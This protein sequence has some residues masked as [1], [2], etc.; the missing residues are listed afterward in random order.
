MAAFSVLTSLL[1]VLVY[2]LC[3]RTCGNAL[4]AFMGGVCGWFF[5]TVGL[6][7][8]P[9]LIGHIFLVIELIVLEIAW[10]GRRRVL[11]FLPPLFAIWV[12]CHGSYFFGLGVLFAYTL[13]SFCGGNWG[14]ISGKSWD[15]SGRRL[16]AAILILSAAALC[17]NP[18]GVHLLIY[19]LN[20]MFQQS[21][22]TTVV[23]EWQAPD[24]RS[25]T[26]IGMI[27]ALIA[28]FMIA[29][30]R[31]A[32]I[33]IRELL[34]VGAALALASQH[35]RVLFIFGI[36]VSP[37]LCRLAGPVLGREHRK[38]LPI[39]NA[40]LIA[41]FVAIIAANFPRRE[42]LERQVRE[43][44]PVAAV[45]FIRR[46]QLNGPMLNEYMFGDYL[47]WALPEHKVFI[48]GRGD[49][50]DWTGVFAEMARWAMLKEDPE[51]LLNRYR[52]GFCIL[53]KESAMTQVL[54]HL[55][56]WRQAY[57]DKV[58]VVFVR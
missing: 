26:G 30:L 47:I 22:G 55:A 35:S 7:I 25:A 18:V 20:V 58:A 56:G 42:D 4:V 1:L 6:S 2:V 23:E 52:I 8:R 43:K 38:E 54:P 53:A 29:L 15:P 19:P 14:L 48:D 5:A 32:E 33:Q 28:V 51:L 12:N 49:V 41:A 44:S 24:L 31:R 50:Y 37:V 10:Q 46:A 34:T 40:I 11:W 16:L 57:A 3:Y 17:V 45:E 9:L 21:V 39:A 13:A 36:M 27:A